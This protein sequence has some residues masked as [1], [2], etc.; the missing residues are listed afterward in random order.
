M[1]NQLHSADSRGFMQSTFENHILYSFF[2]RK[3]KSFA[4]FI[5]TY[6]ID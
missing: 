4:T 3:G 5:L 6:Y 2:L 1:A